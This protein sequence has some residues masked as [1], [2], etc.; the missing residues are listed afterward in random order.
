MANRVL[1][2][3]VDHQALK[4]VPRHGAEFGDAV[5]QLLVV[6]TE[7]EAVQREFP[8]FL[9][10]DPDGQFQSVALLGFERGENLFLDDGRWNARYIPAV[11]RRGPFFVA[12]RPDGDPMIHIDLDDPRVGAPEGEPLF[13][14]HG[15][16]APYLEHVAEALF[17]I[18][19]G[20]AVAP[21]MFA[22]FDEL[23][24]IQP[25]ELNVDLGDGLSYTIPNFFTIGQ[26]PFAALSGE[27]LERLNR[28]G[29]LA[30]A[31]FIRGSLGNL[32]R[33]IELKNRARELG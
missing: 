8:I 23:G 6:P 31:V 18:H 10:K 12:I 11:Q 33:L 21:A 26:E 4:V 30:P 24:L 22:L 2:D 5:N 16:N 25:I 15:G 14:P 32:N 28:S 1:L 7:Y 9:R 19:E 13:M 27:A 17:T 3:N 29:F 20:L